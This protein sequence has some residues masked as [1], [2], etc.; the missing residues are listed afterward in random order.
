[1]IAQGSE[2]HTMPDETH[3]NQVTVQTVPVTLTLKR[4]TKSPTFRITFRLVMTHQRVQFGRKRF[5]DSGDIL[6]ECSGLSSERA[7][8]T[9]NSVQGEQ[10]GSQT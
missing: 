1:M 3:K 6:D 9:H 7:E 5:S 2:V 10:L 4:L 8:G